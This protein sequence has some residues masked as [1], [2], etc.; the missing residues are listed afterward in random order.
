M[1]KKRKTKAEQPVESLEAQV[2]VEKQAD[3]I[4]ENIVEKEQIKKEKP[5]RASR[6]ISEEK[7]TPKVAEVKTGRIIRIFSNNTAMIEIN[8]IRSLVS[9]GNANR[10]K[11]GEIIRL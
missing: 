3:E 5:K 1:A 10:Y 8:G 2:M 6:K 9:L 4:I 7:K 11:V